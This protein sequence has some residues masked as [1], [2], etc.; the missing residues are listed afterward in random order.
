MPF[1]TVI[2][3]KPNSALQGPMP[4]QKVSIID[5]ARKSGLSI[6]TVSRVLNGK[7][8]QFRISEKSQQKIKDTAQKLNYIPNQF[9]ANLKSGKSNTI[10]LIIPSL[11][12]PFFAGIAS[13]I[14]TEVR[15]RGYITIIGDSDED[16]EVENEE[17]LQM[18]SR[19]IEGLVIAPCSHN[20]DSIRKLYDRGLPVVCIDRYFK[21][22]EIPYV[23]TDNYEGAMMAT[24]HLIDYGHKRIACIQGVQDSIPN[25]LRIQ[26]FQEAMTGA[27]LTDFTISG[28]DFSIQNGYKETK[29]LLQRE[30]RPTAIFTLSTTI[31]M[32]CLKALRE[33]NL[34]VPEDVSL[35]TFDDHPYL[36]FLATP[37]TCVTQPTREICRMVIKFM[38]FMLGKKDIKSNQVLLKPELVY[39]KSVKRIT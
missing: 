28:N 23:S 38:F 4:N 9:A 29:L 2:F 37:L 15:N 34:S 24:K 36:D 18:Q 3:G 1:R 35:I 16:L 26:G 19:N 11:S 8:K 17:L 33:E 6:T 5:I 12:N 31:A 13:E 7:A 14:N 25:I 32:G 10:A 21:D 27:G 20:S 30:P 39:R 22:L